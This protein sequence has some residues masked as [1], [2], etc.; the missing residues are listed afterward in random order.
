MAC[1]SPLYKSSPCVLFYGLL[2]ELS[3]EGSVGWSPEVSGPGGTGMQLSGPDRSSSVSRDV[4]GSEQKNWEVFCDGKKKRTVSMFGRLGSLW[5]CSP[6]P[7]LLFCVG[8]C[9][10]PRAACVR[11]TMRFWRKPSSKTFTVSSARSSL[12]GTNRTGTQTVSCA[13]KL[14]HFVLEGEKI[15]EMSN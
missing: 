15:K 5:K 12:Q 2:R 11:R 1:W 4:A 3:S 14:Q 10:G 9:S 6:S 8:P 13:L 7:R